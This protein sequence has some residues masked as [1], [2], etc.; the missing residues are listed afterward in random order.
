MRERL[1]EIDF[2]RAYA[3]LAVIAI[4]ITG[5]FLYQSRLAYVW[6]QGMRFAVPIFIILSGLV[7][8]QSEKSN[9]PFSV[10]SFWK[11]RL[12][13]IL[14]P[15]ILWS[16][17]FMLY[18]QRHE[19]GNVLLNKTLFIKDYINNILSGMAC[20]HLYFILVI[21]QI[22]L[23]YP[24]LRYLYLKY[25]KLTFLTSFALTLCFQTLIYLSTVIKLRLPQT[26]LPFFMLFPVWIFFFVLGMSISKNIDKFKAVVQKKQILFIILWIISFGLLL[27]DSKITKTQEDSVRPSIIIYAIMSF[28]FFYILSI[29]Y[30]NT[31]SIVGKILDF[32]SE[33]SFLVY[34]S[35]VLVLKV[36]FSALYI[37]DIGFLWESSKYLAITYPLVTVL[38]LLLSYILSYTPITWL[39]GGVN[40][41]KI[42]FRIKRNFFS[43]K[44]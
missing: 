17:I 23:I 13:K 32:I 33:Q 16:L 18:G 42:N 21:L 12:Q 24:I 7:M 1:R 22:Y 25:P 20:Y 40:T 43:E 8:F 30:K 11:K 10:L 28:V 31:Q 5:I 2:I 34:F 15:Y 36:S 41:R 35:H 37:L 44:M 27:V 4:H 9:K 29:K 39:L 38:T 19:L 3:A 26:K 14:V 6:N